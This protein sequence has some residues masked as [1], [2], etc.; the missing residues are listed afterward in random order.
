MKNNQ[1]NTRDVKRTCEN[2]LKIKFRRG[3]EFNGWFYL[4]GKKS[5]RI[6]VPKGRDSIPKGTYNNMAK[7]LS[8]KIEEFDDLLDCPLDHSKYVSILLTR[9]LDFSD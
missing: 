3:K 8:L 1:Y 5:R 2:K 9:L 6:T 7:Q 4:D